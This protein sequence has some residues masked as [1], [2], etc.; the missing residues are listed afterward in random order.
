MLLAL[1]NHDYATAKS[2][3]YATAEKVSTSHILFYFLLMDFQSL[4]VASVH[5]KKQTKKNTLP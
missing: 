3:F 2:G 4:F 1:K 5:T